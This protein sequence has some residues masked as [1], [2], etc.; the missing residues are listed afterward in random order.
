MNSSSVS[1]MIPIETTTF[2]TLYNLSK[3]GKTKEWKIRVESYIQTAKIITSFGYVNSKTI[4]T[5]RVISSGKNSGKINAT[6]PYTQALAEATSKWKRKKE[7]EFFVENCDLKIEDKERMN[8]PLPMLAQDYTK[9][10]LKIK[11]PC[12]IQPKLDGYRCLHSLGTGIL[13][14]RQSKQFLNCD[15][16]LDELSKL[17]HKLRME[18]VGNDL[19]LDGELYNHLGKF[20]DF[21]VLRKKTLRGDDHQKIKQIKYWIYDIIDENLAFRDR[22][23]ILKKVGDIIRELELQ[24]ICVLDTF[25][26][27]KRED[28]T[29]YHLKIVELDYEGTIIRN[30]NGKYTQKYRSYDLQKYKDFRDEEFPIVGFS[31]EQGDLIVFVC[32]T[33]NGH[34]FNVQCKG[35]REDRHEVYLDTQRNPQMYLGKSLWVQFFEYTADGIPRFPKSYRSVKE[36]IRGEKN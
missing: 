10:S 17:N 29:E 9:H 34:Q 30:G 19:V 23:D 2:P 1:P 4:E 6:T 18:L 3:N 13:W 14:S 12:Y 36:S 32:K 7:T 33:K 35:T 24:N 15:H 22:L 11:F 5:T 27:T 21:G 16:I 20:E 25:E 26:V 8:I 28:I 31:K